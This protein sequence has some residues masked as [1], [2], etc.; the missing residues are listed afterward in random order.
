LFRRWEANVLRRQYRAAD[1]KLAV[2]KPTQ[3][4]RVYRREIRHRLKNVL[5]G[6][7][8]DDPAFE[9]PRRRASS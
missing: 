4:V 6:V 5:I 7:R 9:S 1:H 2:I 3:R 8:F